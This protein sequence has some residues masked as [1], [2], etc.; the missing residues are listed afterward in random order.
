M[1]ARGEPLGADVLVIPHHGSRTSSTPRFIDTVAPKLGILSVG[2]MNRFHHPNAGVVERYL[3]R[4]VRLERTDA[5]GALHIVL[6]ASGEA[7]PEAFGQEGACRYWSE[8]AGCATSGTS[9]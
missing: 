2:Y 1:M 6:P 9:R 5:R 7:P 8:R 3:A 4:G